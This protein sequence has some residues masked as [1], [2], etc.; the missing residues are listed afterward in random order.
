MQWD[1]VDGHCR[2]A[3]WAFPAGRGSWAVAGS[4]L[5]DV[6]VPNGQEPD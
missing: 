4:D 1:D 2:R 6:H 5:L 3:T